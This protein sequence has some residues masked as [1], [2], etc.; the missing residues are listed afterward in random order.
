MGLRVEQGILRSSRRI[1]RLVPYESP[2]YKAW[3]ECQ[4]S[5]IYGE[6]H[7]SVANL[8]KKPV[9]GGEGAQFT[10]FSSEQIFN[11]VITPD[12]KLVMG[13]GHIQSDAILIR[14]FR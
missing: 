14:N 8:W 2:A 5:L 4:K 6:T 10:H 13:R 12:G 7:N 3:G 1:M 11:S 9:S